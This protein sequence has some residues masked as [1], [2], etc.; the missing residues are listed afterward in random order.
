MTKNKIFIVTFLGIAIVGLGIGIAF[1]MESIKGTPSVNAQNQVKSLGQTSGESQ[2]AIGVIGREQHTAT[3]WAELKKEI[4]ASD[5]NKKLYI[6]SNGREY[7][8][9]IPQGLESSVKVAETQLEQFAIKAAELEKQRTPEQR[10]EVMK[11]IQAMFGVNEVEFLKGTANQEYYRDNAGF[12]YFVSIPQNKV[13][14]RQMA[15]DFREKNADLIGE[16][17][18]WKKAEI[19]KERATEIVAGFI[20]NKSG[21]SQQNAEKVI[22]EMTEETIKG[23]YAFFYGDQGDNRF[24]F[25]I[26]IEPV[27]GKIVRYVNYLD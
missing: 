22:S 18:A 12:E 16:S 10:A 3:E 1:G 21:I 2:K 20:R 26:G 25:E 13:V 23:N 11:N 24:Q 17:G 27:T 9:T 14:R 8:L 19:T 5:L 4:N 6:A 7:I 15:R